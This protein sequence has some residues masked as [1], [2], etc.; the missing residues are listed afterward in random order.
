MRA[1]EPRGLVAA[2]A[3]PDDESFGAGGTLATVAA[4]GYP[5]WVI[6]ATNGDEGGVADET[7]DHAMDPEVRR[8]ELRCA[9]AALGIAPPIFLGYRDSGMENWTPKPGAFVLMDRDEVV[10]RISDEIRRLRP[11]VVVTFD[12]SGG[13]GHPDHIRISEVATTAFERTHIE[14]GGPRALY[15][16]VTSRTAMETFMVRWEQ[17]ARDR[18]ETKEPTE[19]DLLQRRRFRELSRPDH[20]ITTKVDV[21]AVI[22]RKLEA[23]ACHASQMRDESWTQ[24]NPEELE[25]TMGEESFVRVEPKPLPGERET[26]LLGLE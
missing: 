23:L 2:F 18:G 24:R 7:G 1:N 11:A 6:C 14:A 26:T 22:R 5:V 16:Q 9:C 8:S 4:A 20:E 13:Y 15:H 12:P 17:D 19:D 10:S 3:H 21:R 25:A